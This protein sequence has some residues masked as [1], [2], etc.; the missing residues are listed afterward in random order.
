MTDAITSLTRQLGFDLQALS[1]LSQNVANASTP[2]YRSVRALPAFEAHLGGAAEP[3]LHHDA[4]EG[5]LMPTGR[6][7]DLALRGEGYFVLGSAEGLVLTRAGEFRR[8][9]AGQLADALDRPVLSHAGAIDLPDGAEVA[10]D[11]EGQVSV[12]GEVLARLLILQPTA[13]SRLE[14]TAGGQRLVG[15]AVAATARVEQG[16]L[17]GANVDA[18]REMIALVELGRH[19]ESLQR[20]ISAYDRVLDIGINRIGDA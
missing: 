20:A 18:A 16:A 6:G 19:A 2:G 3:R 4:S 11:A 8:N 10:V 5:R 13:T 12:D 17:E 15:D 14:P 7:L 9:A 1:A